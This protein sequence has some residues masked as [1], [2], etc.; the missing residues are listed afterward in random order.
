MH[1]S[2]KYLNT[3]ITVYSVEIN[4]NSKVFDELRN[5]AIHYRTTHRSRYTEKTEINICKYQYMLFIE[6]M[7]RTLY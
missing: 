5:Y 2:V 6:T 7:I 1:K 3:I 4:L